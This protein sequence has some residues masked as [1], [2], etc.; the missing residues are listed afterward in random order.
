MDEER[1]ECS[2][3]INKGIYGRSKELGRD[4]KSGRKLGEDGADKD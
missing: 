1:A 2:G 3:W 4:E